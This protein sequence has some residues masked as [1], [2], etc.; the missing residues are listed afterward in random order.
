MSNAK[1]TLPLTRECWAVALATHKHYVICNCLNGYDIH[2][3][4]FLRVGH[5]WCPLSV[6]LWQVWQF[7]RKLN[8]TLTE[9][10]LVLACDFLWLMNGGWL[11]M[12]ISKSNL[13]R[14]IFKH[15]ARE[16]SLLIRCLKRPVDGISRQG[17]LRTES[18]NYSLRPAVEVVNS[19]LGWK[20]LLK[21]LRERKSNVFSCKI[22]FSFCTLYIQGATICRN[23]R[24]ELTWIITIHT[25]V[26]T[27]YVA[28]FAAW[29]RMWKNSSP[30]PRLKS[31]FTGY[32]R[33]P[34]AK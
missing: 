8:G 25:R 3:M 26:I 27:H 18:H 17:K 28:H 12:I 30:H 7:R 15:I 4:L 22:R 20:N 14:D 10:S 29:E 11:Y 19:L 2:S 24:L 16:S 1:Q 31:L 32:L 21:I 6:F 34:P 23:P 33:W 13:Y 5:L 9:S